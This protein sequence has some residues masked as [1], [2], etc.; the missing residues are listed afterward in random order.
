M[1]DGFYW[2]Q[3]QGLG[4]LAISNLFYIQINFKVDPNLS[5][6]EVDVMEME[7]FWIYHDDFYFYTMSMEEYKNALK[8]TEWKFKKYVESEML[9]CDKEVRMVTEDDQWKWFIIF[10]TCSMSPKPPYVIRPLQHTEEE[11]QILLA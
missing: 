10:F 5:G 8:D 2:S 11:F 6:L 9:R 7:T 3:S 1:I 4:I